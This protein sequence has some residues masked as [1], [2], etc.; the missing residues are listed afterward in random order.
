MRRTQKYL[1]KKKEFT[2]QKEW[3]TSSHFFVNGVLL[4]KLYFAIR[5]NKN[6]FRIEKNKGYAYFCDDCPREFLQKRKPTL[7]QKSC[8]KKRTGMGTF[9]HFL[10]LY[11]AF[12]FQDFLDHNWLGIDGDTQQG[13]SLAQLVCR[14]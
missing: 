3:H 8:T 9:L 13:G 6:P 5:K 1:Y 4:N 12:G 2:V 7:L 10:L 14:H 11:N